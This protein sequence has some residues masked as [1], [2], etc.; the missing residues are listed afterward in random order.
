[1]HNELLLSDIDMVHRTV[2]VLLINIP[3]INA[4]I[5]VTAL[6]SDYNLRMYVKVITEAAQVNW[7]F[8]VKDL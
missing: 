1:M 5:K 6:V 4:T 3:V 8:T 7:E 2:T